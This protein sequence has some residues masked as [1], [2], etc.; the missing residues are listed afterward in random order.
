MLAQVMQAIAPLP[1]RISIRGHTDAT[2]FRSAGGYNNWDLSADR[3][4]A[5]RRSLE[6]AGLDPSRVADVVGRADKDPLFADRPKAAE[7]RR[8][9]IVLLRETPAGPGQAVPGGIPSDSAAAAAP[10]APAPARPA[11]RR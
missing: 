1:N 4:N 11:P 7:N 2:P 9:S 10:A 5:T 8:I 3:A 6:Q